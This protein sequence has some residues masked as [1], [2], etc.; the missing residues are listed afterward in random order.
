MCSGN[1]GKGC[2]LPAEQRQQSFYHGQH[3]W[4]FKMSSTSRF[5][6]KKRALLGEILD[7]KIIAYRSNEDKFYASVNH[8]SILVTWTFFKL[9]KCFLIQFLC[10]IYKKRLTD[11]K[12]C[13]SLRISTQAQKMRYTFLPSGNSTE[14]RIYTKSTTTCSSYLS[15]LKSYPRKDKLTDQFLY[16]IDNSTAS[17]YQSPDKLFEICKI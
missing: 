16:F 10:R 15:F 2:D 12:K 7:D 1:L 5:G 11:C 3:S 4:A 14:A 6:T 17:E 13:H 8:S 9:L